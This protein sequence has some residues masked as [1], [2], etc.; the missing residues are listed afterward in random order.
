VR[1]EADWHRVHDVAWR[2]DPHLDT[3]AQ[4]REAARSVRHSRRNC[5]GTDGKK[6]CSWRY[7]KS[8]SGPLGLEEGGGDGVAQDV[9]LVLGQA[10]G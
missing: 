9:C 7:A 4:R 1:G 8:C 3:Q 6:S 5:C 2:D 10:G